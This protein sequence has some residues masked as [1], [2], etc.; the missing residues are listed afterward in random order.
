MGDIIDLTKR[1]SEKKR[2][3]DKQVG[4]PAKVIKAN[5]DPDS[6]KAKTHFLQKE[7][8]F[9]S[10]NLTSDIE[11]NPAYMERLGEFAEKAIGDPLSVALLPESTR[12]DVRMLLG[13]YFEHKP[14]PL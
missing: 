6:I 11:L 1:L 8:Y 3:S 2:E 9:L 4:E 13:F 7:S 12:Q 5:F 10:T 14:V